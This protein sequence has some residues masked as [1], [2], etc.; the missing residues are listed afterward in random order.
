MLKVQFR[1]YT[2]IFLDEKTIIETKLFSKRSIYADNNNNRDR[3]DINTTIYKCVLS[4][5]EAHSEGGYK[6]P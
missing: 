1:K 2:K 6:E 5:M 3:Y 4:E